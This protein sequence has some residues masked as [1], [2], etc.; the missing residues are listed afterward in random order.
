M[1][2]QIRVV[3]CIQC[4]MYQVS[5]NKLKYILELNNYLYIHT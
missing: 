4:K 5:A 1:S 3:Q 2:Q